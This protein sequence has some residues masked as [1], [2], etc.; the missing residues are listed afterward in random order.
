MM[1]A[2]RRTREGAS[3]FLMR[4]PDQVR[5]KVEVAAK[6]S[7]SSLNAE[8]LRRLEESFRKENEQR[9]AEKIVK[10]T[11]EQLGITTKSEDR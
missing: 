7:G 6:S 1:A 11:L 2:R 4:L 9:K 5:D 10:E 8:I 3:N